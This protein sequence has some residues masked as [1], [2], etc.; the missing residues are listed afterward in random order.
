MLSIDMSIPQ[1][2]SLESKRTVLTWKGAALNVFGTDM[3]QRGCR[4]DKTFLAYPAHRFPCDIVIQNH[5]LQ[6]FLIK[7][8]WS[9]EACQKGKTETQFSEHGSDW[10]TKVIDQLM[11]E[12]QS[13][14]EEKVVEQIL[15]L[16]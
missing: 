5:F 2:S 8:G 10:K 13:L 14:I 4:I 1:C 9:K 16:G 11:F 6:F 12:G 15:D 7:N 3:I